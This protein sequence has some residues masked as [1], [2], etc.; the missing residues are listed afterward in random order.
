M[1]FDVRNAFIDQNVFF[2]FFHIVQLSAESTNIKWKRGAGAGSHEMHRRSQLRLLRDCCSIKESKFNFESVT[3]IVNPTEW[4]L[5]RASSQ[6][7]NG[8][9]SFLRRAYR[10]HRTFYFCSVAYCW[11]ICSGRIHRRMAIFRV[12]F[13]TG[14][15]LM[16]V[17]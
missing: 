12:A 11:W 5:W 8:S 14:D 4:R 17:L 7:L 1:N 3:A 10:L 2:R 6:C 9:F 13:N 16:H 15:R